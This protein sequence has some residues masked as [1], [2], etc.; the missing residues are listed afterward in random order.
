VQRISCFVFVAVFVV[1]SFVFVFP[2]RFFSVFV[3]F[4]F[5]LSFDLVFSGRLN[6]VGL[7]PIGPT[8]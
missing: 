4:G 2:L 3:D 5:V 6:R 7:H 8:L 1:F